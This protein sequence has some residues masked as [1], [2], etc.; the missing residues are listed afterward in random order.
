MSGDF[1]GALVNSIEAEAAAAMSKTGK[2]LTPEEVKSI[3][4]AQF[5][6]KIAPYLYEE[7][8]KEGQR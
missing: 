8:A 7:H 4:A 2:A 1:F 6:R 3:K 5:L